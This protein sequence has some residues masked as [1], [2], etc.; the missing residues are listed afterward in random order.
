MISKQRRS[1]GQV[2]LARALSKLGLT[3]RSQAAELIRAGRVAVNG[4]IVRRADRWLD[5][6]TD[7][8][9]VDSAIARPAARRYLMMHKPAGFVTTR[10]DERGRK[11]VYDLLPEEFSRCFPVGRLDRD[12]SGLLLFTNDTRFGDY[13]TNPSTKMP[14]TYLV[15][16][17]AVMND[18]SIK[19]LEKGL[20]TSNG[21]KYLPA[22]VSKTDQPCE[23]A[24]TIEEG[25]NRQV[26]RMMSEVGHVVLRLQRSSIGRV[27]LGNL[28]E[29]KSR[30]LTPGELGLLG[31]HS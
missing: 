5:P 13:V 22:R 6:K 15:R 31:W 16:L 20:A 19:R 8:I 3:S 26:R 24:V 23:Y 28:P 18:A 17:D 25:K 14:K 1:R 29:G 11:T 4:E 30:E 9:A 27:T 2:T 10:S 12:S 7:N 21:I